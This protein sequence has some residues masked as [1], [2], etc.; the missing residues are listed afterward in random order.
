MSNLLNSALI[1]KTSFRAESI[2]LLT[3]VTNY[4]STNWENELHFS[5]IKTG[6]E[7]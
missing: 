1:Y 5:Q 7:R 3:L 2:R 4:K 6:I